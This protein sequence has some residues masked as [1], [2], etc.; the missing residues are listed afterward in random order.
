VESTRLEYTAEVKL[1]NF[2]KRVFAPWAA[3]HGLPSEKS[4]WSAGDITTYEEWI[5]QYKDPKSYPWDYWSAYFNQYIVPY[6]IET[7]TPIPTRSCKELQSAADIQAPPNPVL[8]AAAAYDRGNN[9]WKQKDYS[10]A[11]TEYEQACTGG[12]ASGCD[13]LGVLYEYGQGVAQDFGRASQLFKQA[14]D[15]GEMN[16]CDLLGDL[17]KSGHGVPQDRNRAL[18]LYDLACK[19]GVNQGCTDRDALKSTRSN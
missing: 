14:C 6:L 3:S 9:Y 8:S 18:E 15:D 4:Y 13:G 11:F 2:Y 5:G 12:N 16:G 1:S 19:G 17:Y 10:H 7:K